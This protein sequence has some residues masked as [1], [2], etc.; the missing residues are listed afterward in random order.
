M[1]ESIYDEEMRR[2]RSSGGAVSRETGEALMFENE[3]EYQAVIK[4]FKLRHP[5]QV[6]KFKRSPEY[7]RARANGNKYA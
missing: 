5:A 2:L 4:K 7:R 1:A 3:A 6:K